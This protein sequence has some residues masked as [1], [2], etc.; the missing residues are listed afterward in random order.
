MSYGFQVG[1]SFTWGKSFDTSSSSF[2]SDNYSNN[3]SAI[4]PWYDMSINK[5]LSDF[6]VTR[7]LSIN[8]LWRVP[9]P[10]AFHGPLGYVTGG[11]GLGAN[12]EV[13]DGIPL[14]PLMVAGDSVGMDI[15]GAYSIPSF[16]PGCKA[17]NP[18]TGRTGSLQYINPDCYILPVAP[19]AAFYNAPKPLGCDSMAPVA[20]RTFPVSPLTCPNLLGNDPR[21]AI[22][23]PGLINLDFSMTKDNHI[24][25]I[26]ETTNLQ[27]RAEFFNITNR[28]NYAPPVAND[29]GSLD[30]DGSVIPKFGTLS[31]VQVPMRE[32]QFALKLIW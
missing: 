20:S 6:N 7:N 23:G 10:A 17:T 1:G 25:K 8:F 15:T 16:V 12:F 11:W 29:L 14:W 9:T 30:V 31:Q 5:G 21:N 2:A 13:S 28:V 19:S 24:K 18:S 27:F 26:S 4:T 32:I 3:P 22:I